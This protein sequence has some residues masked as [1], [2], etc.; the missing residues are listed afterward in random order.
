MNTTTSLRSQLMYNV[1]ALES[2]VRKGVPYAS[3]NKERRVRKQIS[4][5]RNSLSRHP[6]FNDVL[7]VASFWLKGRVRRWTQK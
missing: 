7:C 3:R 4:A 1:S 5:I 2:T 6:S